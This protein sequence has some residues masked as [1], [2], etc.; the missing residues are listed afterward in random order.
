MSEDMDELEHMHDAYEK[1]VESYNQ[2]QANFLEAIK[3]RNAARR[4]LA[5]V[6]G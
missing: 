4:E 2:S 5:E 1:V 3:Q 6:K